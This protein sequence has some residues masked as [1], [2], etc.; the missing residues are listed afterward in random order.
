[1]LLATLTWFTI[2]TGLQQ[3][4]TMQQSPVSDGNMRPF[5]SLP[6]TILTAA[7]DTRGF[8]VIPDHV[9]VKVI[10]KEETLATV[11]P[12]EI[13]VFV[14]LTG[15]QSENRLHKT[16]Q[17]RVPDGVIVVSVFPSRVDVE[18]IATAESPAPP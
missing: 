7:S 3:T 12:N 15:N 13:V 8:K 1:M 17:V 5:Q 18:P 9:F 6:I 11:Q 2:W 10:G 16:V 4:K 14:D